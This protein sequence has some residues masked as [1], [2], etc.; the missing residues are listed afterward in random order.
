MTSPAAR[1]S[2][3]SCSADRWVGTER[4]TSAGHTAASGSKQGMERFPVRRASRR[5]SIK[6]PEGCAYS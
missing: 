6:A 4:I 5:T 2:A 1:T 3:C